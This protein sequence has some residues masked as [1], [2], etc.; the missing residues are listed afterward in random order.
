MFKPLIAAICVLAV[1]LAAVSTAD[2]QSRGARAKKAETVRKA[3]GTTR[4][5]QRTQVRAAS[6]GTNGLCQRDTGTPTAQL[7]FRNRCDTEEFWARILERPGA[8]DN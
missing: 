6:V 5:V 8:G 7:N 3:A 2:A 4:S 1:P